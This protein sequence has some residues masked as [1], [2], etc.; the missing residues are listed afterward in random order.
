[1][2][3]II[4]DIYIIQQRYSELRVGQIIVIAA[5]KGGWELDDVFSCPDEVLKAGLAKWLKEKY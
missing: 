5:R 3:D 1:M 4:R 2:A